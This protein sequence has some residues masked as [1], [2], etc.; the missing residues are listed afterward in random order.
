MLT[1]KRVVHLLRKRCERAGGVYKW[2][3]KNGIPQPTIAAAL[4][5]GRPISPAILEIMNLER[6]Y[7]YKKDPSKPKKLKTGRYGTLYSDDD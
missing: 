6:V 2:A 1:H 5:G 7:R 3:A 4:N